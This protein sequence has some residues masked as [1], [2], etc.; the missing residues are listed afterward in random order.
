M[1][2][3]KLKA[4]MLQ[5]QQSLAKQVENQE[6]F[7]VINEENLFHLQGGSGGPCDDVSD[8]G[9]VCT[10]NSCGQY[11]SCSSCDQNSC[12]IY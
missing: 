9:G 1:K 11:T 10:T 2:N 5:Q 4:L 12:K 3:S 6:E 8:D 7:V